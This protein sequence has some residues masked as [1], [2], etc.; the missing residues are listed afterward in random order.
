MKKQ[1]L[2]K[3]RVGLEIDLSKLF[4]GP[5]VDDDLRM[6][7]SGAIMDRIITRTL[8][9]YGVD[10]GRMKRFSGYSPAYAKLKGQKNVDLELAGNMLN[11]I[12]V[13]K[14][15]KD[16]LE[17]GIDDANAP[18][19]HGHL[20]GQEGIG[21]LPRRNFLDL[22]E[23]ELE[24]IRRSFQKEVEAT[25]KKKASSFFDSKMERDVAELDRLGITVDDIRDALKSLKG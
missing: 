10:G 24:T 23:S 6:L 17:I 19:A 16:V 11:A 9:G 13:L 18:K 12:S 22:A 20:T 2:D 3:T 15:R 5:V 25:W 7:I 8:K 14:S 1:N 4:G 21:P